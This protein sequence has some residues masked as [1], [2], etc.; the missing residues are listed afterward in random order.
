M[1]ILV[2]VFALL[3]GSVVLA[4]DWPQFRGADRSGISKEKGLLPVWPKGG[5]PLAW[6]FKQTGMGHSSFAVVKGVVYTLGTDM[7][8]D[9]REEYIFAIDES[10]GELLWKHKLGPTLTIKGGNTWGDGPRSTPT[11]DGSLLYALSSIG[12]LV[13][14]D[15]AD[16]GKE[17]WRKNLVKEFR[18]QMMTEWGYSESPL[19]DGDRLVITP[20]GKDGTLA[21]LD[22]KTGNLLWRSKTWTDKAPYSSIVAADINGTRQYIQAGFDRKNN[23][24]NLVAVEAA[25]GNKLWSARLFENEEFLAI[26]STPIVIGN[27]IYVSCGGS[28]GG[29]SHLFEIDKKNK[30]TEKFA[31]GNL[32]KFKNAYGGVVLIDGHI[33][34]HTE[35]SAWGCQNLA[36]GAIAW[37]NRD[38][39]SCDS[40]AIT[41]A[42]GKLYLYSDD[43]EVG[44]MDADPKA[45]N[46]VGSF[47]LP[48]RSKLR[49][50]VG[51]AGSASKTWAIPVIANGNLYLRDHELIFK[52]KITK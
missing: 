30:V 7:N 50:D 49:Q 41:A 2:A 3:V 37:T 32:K 18:G 33:Y 24:G 44:L 13:C 15:I 25:T 20:G 21:A 10:K 26:G 31:R 42:E 14:V 51:A 1:R 27:Q 39:L 17:I 16:K 34:G 52:Y 19:V 12:E 23:D 4:D 43:G 48:Q 47:T 28:P 46:L 40:G 35:K 38:A 9:K 45:S 8:I 11:I 5:P 22:K 36:D 6:T 29:N